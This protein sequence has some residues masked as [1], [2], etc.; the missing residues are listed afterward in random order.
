MQRRA[1]LFKVSMLVIVRRLFDLGVF[2]RE[3]LSATYHTELEHLM[4]LSPRGNGG[5]DFYNSLSARTGKRFERALV[6]STPEG[7]TQFTDAFRMLGIKK[8]ATFYEAAR[9][10]GLHG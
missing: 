6:A 8:S 3:T 9:R 10:L 5:G 1:C 4:V 2:D 7:Q